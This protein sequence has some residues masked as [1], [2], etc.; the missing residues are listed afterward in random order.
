[1]PHPTPARPFERACPRIHVLSDIHLESGDYVLPEELDYD[2]LV[3]AGDIGPLDIAVPWLAQLGKPVV[4][5]LGNHE[6]WRQDLGE[7]VDYA[8]KLACG[9]QVTVLN[10]ESV[11][12]QDVVFLGATLWTNLG[13]LEPNVVSSVTTISRDYEFIRANAW[14]SHADN[15]QEFSTLC[16]E[17]ALWDSPSFGHNATLPLHPGMVAIEHSRSVTWLESQLR[18]HRQERDP[19]HLVVVTHH[20]PSQQSLLNSGTPAEH[21]RSGRWGPRNI[22]CVKSWGYA[23]P[24]LEKQ[25]SAVAR[26]AS[27]W[28][29]GH[30]HHGLDYCVSGTRVLCNP[31]G[32]AITAVTPEIAARYA[33]LG[34]PV[35]AEQVSRSRSDAQ[36]YLG[37]APDFDRNLVLRLDEGFSRPLERALAPGRQALKELR[38]ELSRLAPL[39]TADE[40]LKGACVEECV[41]SRIQR[42]QEIANHSS[43]ILAEAWEADSAPVSFALEGLRPPFFAKL[44]GH[45]SELERTALLRALE[46]AETWLEQLP[47]LIQRARAHRALAVQAVLAEMCARGFPVIEIPLPSQSA[48]SFKFF[49]W[50]RLRADFD[51]EKMEQAMSALS[52]LEGRQP[53]PR[54]WLMHLL[55]E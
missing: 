53:I 25:I 49:N 13:A 15:A 46:A 26:V 38:E 24:L 50:I 45:S 47:S 30:I 21:L 7:A 44:T 2:I 4:Y 29:H 17:H 42:A 11:V 14:L 12:I 20:A 9:T 23:T 36:S 6:F 55:E 31:R 16:A 39:L 27:A 35:S 10:R 52:E 1:M 22:D 34:H 3:A 8:K 18:A 28:V 40:G 32:K 41:A 51:A 33:S 19:R 37:L 48:Q 5:V 54:P 43:V